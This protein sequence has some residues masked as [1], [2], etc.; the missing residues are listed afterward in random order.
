MRH[1][2]YCTQ[3]RMRRNASKRRFRGLHNAVNIKYVHNIQKLQNC[4]NSIEIQAILRYSIFRKLKK[5]GRN[6]ILSINCDA[7]SPAAQDM[8][9][10]ARCA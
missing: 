4:K 2:R 9:L 7:V 10:A 8:V 1:T 3:R 5:V 6:N